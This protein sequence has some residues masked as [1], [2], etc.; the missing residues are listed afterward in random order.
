M[1]LPIA[2]PYA[3]EGPLLQLGAPI[4]HPLDVME[5]DRR[6]MASWFHFRARQIHISA[7]ATPQRKAPAIN[8]HPR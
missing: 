1:R 8:Q 5:A 7:E 4:E 3:Q 6:S 2:N